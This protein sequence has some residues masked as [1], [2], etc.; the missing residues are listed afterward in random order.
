MTRPQ[1][2]VCVVTWN[3]AD[4][5]PKALRNLLDTDQ[6]CD[7][8]IFVRDNASSDGSVEAVSRLVPEADIVAATDNIGF[9]RGQNTL[10]ER[11]TAPWIL[12]LNPDAWPQPGAIGALI[13]AAERHPRAAIVAPRLENPDGTLQHSTHPFPSVATAASVAFAWKRISPERA[14][15]LFLEGT[16]MH[17]RERKIDWALAAVWLVRREA[18]EQVG[19]FDERFFM[20]AEDLDLA[21]RMT[22]AGWEV[23]FEPTSTFRHV[24]NVSGEQKF[25]TARTQAHIGNA[26]SFYVRA[27][28]ILPA[29][30]WWTLN[31]LGSIVRLVT[32]V[33]RRDGTQ[34]RAWLAT[35][36]ANLFAPFD[37]RGRTKT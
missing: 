30:A 1:V 11:G 29:V 8:R 18:I 32:S 19:G 36:K 6:G 14:D 23:W 2:D 17:D 22:Q 3:T 16:W 25:G 27:H 33:V 20:Y 15:E 31:V 37:R 12:V 10:F 34:A 7:V 9:G 5:T 28:G 13:A 35:L 24:L 21:W 26:L 4:E